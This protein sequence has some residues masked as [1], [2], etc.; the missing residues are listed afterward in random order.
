MLYVVKWIINNHYN[1][2]KSSALI[3]KLYILIKVYYILSSALSC[4][5]KS[6]KCLLLL[7]FRNKCV[8]GFVDLIPEA[9]LTNHTHLV[10]WNNRNIFFQSSGS[11]TSQIKVWQ[12]NFH[13]RDSKG[14]SIPCVFQLLVVSLTFLGLRPHHFSLCFS[15][16]AG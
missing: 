15:L 5:E 8:N 14:Q 1:I 10:A 4:G 12:D 11:S 2:M 7:Y 9:A 16:T 3:M 6:I 13:F